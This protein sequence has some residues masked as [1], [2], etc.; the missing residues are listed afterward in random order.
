MEAIQQDRLFDRPAAIRNTVVYALAFVGAMVL[1]F[2]SASTWGR[3]GLALV[4]TWTIG[5]LK[6]NIRAIKHG[7]PLDN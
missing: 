4:L 7:F 6:A 2:W 3:I 1:L 5:G